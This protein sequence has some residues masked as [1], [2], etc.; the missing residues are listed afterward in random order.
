MGQQKRFGVLLLDLPERGSVN[1]KKFT[2]AA[3]NSF[4]LAVDLLSREIDKECRYFGK[5]RLESKQLVSLFRRSD[6]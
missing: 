6:L 4:N 3:L 2:E 1:F 5:Q